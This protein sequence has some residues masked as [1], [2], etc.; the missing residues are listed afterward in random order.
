MDFKSSSPSG[1]S[2]Q[3]DPHPK[4]EESPDQEVSP[5]QESTPGVEEP[6][7]QNSTPDHPSTHPDLA[8]IAQMLHDLSTSLTDEN[9]TRASLQV[10]CRSIQELL[11][12]KS[13]SGVE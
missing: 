13:E 7:E 9:R 4:E 8:A 12:Q 10:E 2:S 6:P 1:E 5:E 3:P 11:E